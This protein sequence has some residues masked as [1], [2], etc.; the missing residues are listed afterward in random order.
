MG[1]QDTAG[2]TDNDS[3]GNCVQ[4]HLLNDHVRELEQQLDDLRNIRENEGFLDQTYSEVVTSRVNEARRWVTTSKGITRRTVGADE[5]SSSSQ[6]SDYKSSAEAQQRRAT[7][8]RVTVVGDSI[9]RGAAG[10]SAAAVTTPGWRPGSRT[11][12]SGRRTKWEEEQPEGV[13]HVDTN[14]TGGK[15]N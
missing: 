10:D 8:G 7:S 13:V 3:C 14:D 5:A 2:A 9:I 4:V 6:G 15:K 1:S 12:P 11:C